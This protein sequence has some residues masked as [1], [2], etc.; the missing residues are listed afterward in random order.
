MPADTGLNS[1]AAATTVGIRTTANCASPHTSPPVDTSNTDN[2][3]I[4]ATLPDGC[5]SHVSFNPISAEQQYG[6]A[7]AD[8]VSCGLPA[9]TAQQF[10]PVMFWFYHN[11]TMGQLQ[12]NAI[13]CR[14][15]VEIFNIVANVYLND[16]SL[17]DVTIKDTYVTPNNVSGSPMNGQVFN[18]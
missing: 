11:N 18:A 3:T 5:T 16:R 14:P 10:V 4:S 8:P 13:I 12:A 9:N 17:T 1:S 15:T 2:F 6:T 7:P